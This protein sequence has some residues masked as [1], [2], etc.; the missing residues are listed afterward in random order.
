MKA[1]VREDHERE[2][3]SLN[4][5]LEVA[6]KMNKEQ[7]MAKKYQMVRFVGK[8]P[9]LIYL[10]QERQKA[11]RKLRQAEKLFQQDSSA[12]NQEAVEKY[13]LDLYYTMHFPLTEKYIALYP[14]TTIESKEVLDK[15]NRI[16]QQLKDEMTQRKKKSSGSND[17]QLGK[18]KVEV[19]EDDESDVEKEDTESEEDDGKK[20]ESE[21]DEFLQF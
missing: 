4:K 5:Q 15:Q 1:N 12:E 18:R 9:H 20:G 14:K 8:N 3:G 10:I 21:E 2:L 16:R 7:K 6:T 11:T 19:L 13:T 17:V